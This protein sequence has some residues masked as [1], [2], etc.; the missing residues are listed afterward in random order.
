MIED[1]EEKREI[2]ESLGN[3]IEAKSRARPH[4]YGVQVWYGFVVIG[5]LVGWIRSPDIKTILQYGLAFWLAG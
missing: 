3:M 2:L 5:L 1:P 4:D